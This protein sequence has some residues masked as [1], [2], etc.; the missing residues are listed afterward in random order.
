[1]IPDS[2]LLHDIHGGTWV[3]E[4]TAPH[5]YARRR[6]EVRDTV[7]GVAILTR[8]PETG[9]PVVTTGAAEL[10]GIEFGAGK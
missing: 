10:F 1:V 8:G 7:G 6:V 5:V 4:R 3:Y 9:T 2:A